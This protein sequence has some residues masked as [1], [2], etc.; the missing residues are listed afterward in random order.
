MFFNTSIQE[1]LRYVFLTENKRNLVR[2]MAFSSFVCTY[3]RGDWLYSLSNETEK[4]VVH[5]YLR[6]K[7]KKLYGKGRFNA[8]PK[9]QAFFFLFGV[10]N[11]EMF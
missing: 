8:I 11:E 10:Q 2:R 1:T 3:G 9:S 6:I 7:R 4:K 5:A